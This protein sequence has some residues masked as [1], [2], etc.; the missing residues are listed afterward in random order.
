MCHEVIEGV[1]YRPCGHY[2]RLWMSD[3]RDCKSPT[4]QKSSA[5]A[6]D[7]NKK[8][9]MQDFGPDH[10][11]VSRLSYEECP[12]CVEKYV[13]RRKVKTSHQ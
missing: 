9:C 8:T 2:V 3:I 13:L 7:C 10:E 1:F 12:A 4:C 6:S 11:K 5:H